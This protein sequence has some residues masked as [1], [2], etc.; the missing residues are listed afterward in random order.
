MSQ[1]PAAD[2]GW[3]GSK[4]EACAAAEQV[5][6]ADGFSYAAGTANPATA[7]TGFLCA[8]QRT[9]NP[10]G[11]VQNYSSPAGSGQVRNTVTCPP[12]PGCDKDAPEI[13]KTFSGTAANMAT[14]SY[15]HA[16]SQCLVS[17]KQSVSAGG[18]TIYTG[19]VTDGDCPSDGSAPEVAP[20]DLSEDEACV[21]VGDGS[22]CASPKGGDGSCGFVN[23]SF[24]CLQK[25]KQ[26]ECKPVGGGA[27]CGSQAGT[28]P[29][30]DNGTRGQPATPTGTFDAQV[31]PGQSQTFNY[32]NSTTVS[33]SSVQV[34]DGSN[35]QNSGGSP[36]GNAESEEEE[37][38][39]ASG[40]VG[41][42][43]PPV[44]TGDAIACATLYQA[45]RNRCPGAFSDAEVEAAIGEPSAVPQVERDLSDVLDDSKFG[46]TVQACPQPPQITLGAPLNM[47]FT[48]DVIS[49][50]CLFAGQISGVVVG[51]GWLLSARI[52]MG[53]V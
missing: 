5:T 37:A 53:A 4:S 14:R 19:T 38:G 31:G 15:C 17:V 40:G 39:S 23:S 48:L 12:P 9:W 52:L 2:S 20:D 50:L 29:V 22:Y 45:W 27:V 28:P 47:T 44:C 34:G 10:T 36:G 1:Y 16:V 51:L 24:V 21:A 42:D 26:D 43:A 33:A 25:V 3:V 11:A 46:T 8:G 41:C 49:W 30:P 35:P 13:G 32:Y 7:G 6:R 18:S